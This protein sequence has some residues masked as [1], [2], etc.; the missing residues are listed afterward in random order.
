[1]APLPEN[2]TARLWIDY[3]DTQNDHSLM[4]RFLA[5]DTPL[6]L[7]MEHVHNFLTA[8]SP[9]FFQLTIQ[10]A[11]FA[12]QGSNISLPAT[13]TGD[14]TYGTG[15]LLA[16]N[17]PREVRWVGRTQNARRVSFSLY[18]ADIVTPD[19]YRIVSSGT[20]L[21]NVGVIAINAGSEDGVFVGI[22]GFRPTMKNY[23][24]VNFNSYWETEARG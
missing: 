4:V 17:A 23:V 9:D 10:G 15:T 19:T 11:R 14:S 1:M 13:W 18:G 5:P 20:N 3:N 8:V 6:S 12:A 21:P 7:A 24:N 16:V 2:N 22:D